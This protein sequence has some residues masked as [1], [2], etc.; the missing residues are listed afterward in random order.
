MSNRFELTP[1]E[2]KSAEPSLLSKYTE[3]RG[4]NAELLGALEKMTAFAE[5]MQEFYGIGLEVAAWHENGQTEPLDNFIDDNLDADDVDAARA[6][7][8]RAEAGG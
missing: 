1:W 8:R 7:I 5:A 6:A 4:I 3:L 2:S